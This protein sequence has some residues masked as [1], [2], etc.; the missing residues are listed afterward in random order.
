MNVVFMGSPD[1]AVPSLRALVESRH[2]VTAVVTQPDRPRGRGK[3]L[4]PTPVKQLA[5]LLGLPVLQPEKLLDIKGDL[6]DIAPSVIVVVAFG[7]ILRQDILDIP[8]M[9]CINVHASLL[10]RYRGAAPIHR[11]IINGE[12]STG[13]TT[14]FMDRGLDTGDML[15]KEEVPIYDNDTVGVLHDR[16]AETGA[17]LL[18]KTLDQVENGTAV[19]IPQNEQEATYAPPLTREDEI[20]NWRQSSREIKDLVRGLNPWPGARTTLNGKVLK[21]WQVEDTGVCGEKEAPCGCVLDVDLERGIV[22]KAGEGKV[23][24]TGLQL[25]GGK[26][27]TAPEFLR[28]HCVEAGTVLGNGNERKVNNE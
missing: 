12:K 1:F 24:I 15:L 19:R 10:P 23:L 22:V 18:V 13:I 6:E 9:G 27:M 28:G 21:V 25:Q 16:L 11:A 7:K 20:I 4:I 26:K 3:K 14:M 2:R 17:R 8:P 5:N